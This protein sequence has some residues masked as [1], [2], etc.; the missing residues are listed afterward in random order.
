[1]PIFFH[2]ERTAAADDPDSINLVTF[3]GTNRR[4]RTDRRTNGG[5]NETD[6]LSG[7]FLVRRRSAAVKIF[8]HGGPVI[9]RD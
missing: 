6:P 5:M 2:K 9:D 3:D 4:T 7:H 8:V 1:M